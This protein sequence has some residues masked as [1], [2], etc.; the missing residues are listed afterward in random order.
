MR[1]LTIRASLKGRVSLFS[2]ALL[3]MRKKCVETLGNLN[4]FIFTFPSLYLYADNAKIVL[5]IYFCFLFLISTIF[6]EL[7]RTNE[8]CQSYSDACVKLCKELGV[9]VVDLFNALQKRDDWK[10]ACFT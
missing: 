3:S 5:I 2:A 9:K 6:S 7:V 8:L 4:I 1:V 10:N